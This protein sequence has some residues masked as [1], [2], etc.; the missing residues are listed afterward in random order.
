MMII[1]CGNTNMHNTQ[2]SVTT[3]L[4]KRSLL[5]MKRAAAMM[6]KAARYRYPTTQSVCPTLCAA[7]VE[8][9]FRNTVEP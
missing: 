3:S 4:F 7:C 5:F 9:G 1:S 2:S 8:F 6:P